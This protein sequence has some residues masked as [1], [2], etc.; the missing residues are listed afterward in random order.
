MLVTVCGSWSELVQV[1][2]VPFFTVVAA[3]AKAK[4]LMAT[5][6]VV[7]FPAGGDDGEEG[8]HG[9]LDQ[10]RPGPAHR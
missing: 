6:F 10:L 8:H 2:V 3:G 7:A 9:H 4:S 1:T 5:V